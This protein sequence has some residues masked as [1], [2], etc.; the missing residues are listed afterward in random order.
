MS[1]SW[2]Q[3]QCSL[4]TLYLFKAFAFQVFSLDLVVQIIDIRP[5]MFAPVDLKRALQQQKN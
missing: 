4:K 3:Q 1:C 5:V 2:D